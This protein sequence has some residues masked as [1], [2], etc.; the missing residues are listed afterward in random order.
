MQSVQE[1]QQQQGH[2]QQQGNTSVGEGVIMY[3]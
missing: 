3:G 1:Q 2:G